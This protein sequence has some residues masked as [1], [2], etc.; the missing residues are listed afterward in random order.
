MVELLVQ[1]GYSLA[2]GARFL[3]RLIDER[4]KL[5]ISGSWHAGPLYRVMSLDGKIVVAGADPIASVVQ[6]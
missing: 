6:A 3:K 2:Y 4:V 5:P 1:E